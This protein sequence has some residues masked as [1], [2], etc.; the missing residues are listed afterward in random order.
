MN[1]PTEKCP[2]CDGKGTI[3]PVSSQGHQLGTFVGVTHR[4]SF[5]WACPGLIPA[6]IFNPDLT[7][8]VWPAHAYRN[9]QAAHYTHDYFREHFAPVNATARKMMEQMQARVAEKQGGADE[10]Q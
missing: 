4:G 2:L 1:E 8:F 5:W 6:D 3:S 7:W 9:W 10:P